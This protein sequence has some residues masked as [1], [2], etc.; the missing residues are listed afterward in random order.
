M[1]P[2]EFEERLGIKLQE[3]PGLERMMRYDRRN[4]F[5]LDEGGNVIGLNACGNQL[6]DKKAAFLWELSEL[7]AVN[8]SENLLSVVSIP[9]EMK[10]LVYID[11]SENKKLGKVDFSSGLPDLVKLDLCECNLKELELPS[12]FQKLQ[13]LD[14]RKNALVEVSFL[15]DCP[16]LTWLDLSENNLTEFR[17]PAGFARLEELYLDKNPNL[18]TP[19]KETVEQGMQAT[20]RYLREL[21]R[22]G[23]REHYEVKM[24]IV[25]EGE[26]GK[27]T[28][29][30][31]LQNPKHPVPDPEQLSTVGISIKEGWAFQ[32]LDHPDTAFF[33]NLW[34]FGGQ[35]IQY[36]THQFF[37]TRRSFYVLLADG[38][39]EVANF[40]YWLKAISLLGCDPDMTGKL[41]VLVVLNEKG[42]PI[43][44]VPYDPE[45]VNE[46]Y[47]RLDINKR[48]VDFA[49]TDGRI[50]A[51]Q[52]AI[53]DILSHELPHLP[54][55]FPA[56]W[57]DVRQELYRLRKPLNH[58]DFE[59]FKAICLDKGITEEVSMLDLSQLLHDLGVILHFQEDINL[60]DFIVL[61][62]QW[63]LNAVY[64]ILR[65]DE[66]EKQ[67]GRFDK[68]MLQDIWTERKYSRAEQNH[69]LNLMS[70]D[71][72]EVCFR[73][74]EN[75]GEIYIA[76]QLLPKTGPYHWTGHQMPAY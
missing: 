32:H 48:E 73:A 52:Y 36:M 35:E 46:D 76:P 14:L 12:G 61:N 44:Q 6:T 10:N 2:Q 25:G 29:W 51:L 28:L 59:R 47:P 65:S 41:P 17:L 1:K 68:K 64:D 22:Q 74:E 57:D 38:R 70:K 54:L 21:A 56:F 43:A 49:K 30:N 24:L 31:K 69:L 16:C 45:T 66:V 63:A 39:R 3:E 34:D 67:Q 19:P 7:K 71:N 55:R 20:L 53:K 58:I 8:L 37:L 72:F 50:E 4:S 62:P 5:T 18:S 75:G 15:G 60:A 9:A 13:Y 40:S 33:V 27:T 26:T 11:L 42:N 23:E